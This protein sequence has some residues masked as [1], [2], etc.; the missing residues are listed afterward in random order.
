VWRHSHERTG[1]VESLQT[2]ASRPVAPIYFC[3]REIGGG[4]SDLC[5]SLIPGPDAISFTDF[6]PMIDEFAGNGQL[7]D[8][9]RKWSTRNVR[10][11]STSWR[12]IRK[13]RGYHEPRTK[14]WPSII[15]ARWWMLSSMTALASCGTLLTGGL[16]TTP[17]N[18]TGGCGTLL[19]G[20][21]DIRIGGLRDA[22][23]RCARYDNATHPRGVSK[24]HS[25]RRRRCA[26]RLY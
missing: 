2:L 10:M 26:A 8:R 25:A 23:G 11:F 3:S 18:R 12:Q 5:G 1:A 4:G 21:L 22:A 20:A 15:Y 7:L 6:F 17:R 19:A 14:L 9:L 24:Q 16:E 13:W